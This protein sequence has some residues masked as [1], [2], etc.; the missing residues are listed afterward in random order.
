MSKVLLA[1]APAERVVVV[2]PHLDDGVLSLGAAIASWVR[3]GSRVELLTVF[4]CDPDS[5]APSKGWDGRAGFGTE[6]EAALARRDEDA[7]ASLVLGA[8]PIWLPFGSV[9]YERHGNEEDVRRAVQAAAKGADALL[10]PGF[11]LGHPDHLWLARV[12]IGAR[13]G[14]RLLGL[15]AEQPYTRRSGRQPRAPEWV[16]EELEARLS[17][18]PIPV[19]LRDR[20]AK[21]RAIRRYGSQLPLLGMSRSLRR[22]PHSILRGERIAWVP[23]TGSPPAELA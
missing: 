12:L 19:G 22:G 18:E 11:P 5:Q 20:G 14:C 4:G 7:K 2:S 13:V 6:G 8:T 21:W 9:D 15:Y 16:E 3:R 10:L 17:F 23:A 1:E